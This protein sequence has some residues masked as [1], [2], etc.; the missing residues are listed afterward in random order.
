MR[1]RKLSVVCAFL[2]FLALLAAIGCGAMWF[3]DNYVLVSWNLYPA[4]QQVLDLREEALSISDYNRLSRRLPESSILWKVP[5]QG[6]RLDYTTREI[7]VNTLT[8]GDM[9]TLLYLPWLETVHAENCKDYDRLMALREELPSCQVLYN[10]TIGD[11]TYDQDTTAVAAPGLNPEQ[12]RLLTYLPKLESVNAAGCTD[13]E[14][15]KQ[16]QR[17]HPEWNVVYVITLGGAEVSSEAETLTV[18]NVTA[19]E[20]TVGLPGLT[21]LKELTIVNPSATDEELAA[22]RQKYPQVNFNWYFELLGQRIDPNAEE[23]DLS[24]TPLEAIDQ[25]ESVANRL[26]N[27]KKLILEAGAVSNE[28]MAEFREA[29][30]DDYK[31]VWTVYFTSKCK[32]RTDE[33]I[34]MPIKQGEY[35][36]QEQHVEPLKYCE[37]MVCIDVG[38]A[39]IKSVDFASY[40]PHLKYLIL[41]HTQVSDISAL[42][43]CKELVFLEIDWSIVKDYEPLTGCTALEDLNIGKTY[44]DVTPLCSMTWLKNLW[45]VERGA[46]AAYTLSQALPNTHVMAAGDIT[47]G[48]G[49]RSLPNYYA[50]RDMLGMPYML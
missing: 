42:R 32:A 17:E 13:F 16:V 49:W 35:Y 10:V 36:F 30:R 40:M 7:T 22:F 5:F 18:E 26:P 8:D 41:A 34:F 23:L 29:H 28:E 14:L 20:L 37:D 9:E 38:H 21:R 15:V 12:V 11:Q 25:V 19:E 31:V 44:A 39:P 6:E 46:G 50:M 2:A 33:T 48:Y 47:V 24:A 27:L 1:Y 45:C 43:S 4:H 3:L